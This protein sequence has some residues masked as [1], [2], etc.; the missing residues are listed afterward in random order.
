MGTIIPSHLMR[1]KKQDQNRIDS[2]LISK[3]KLYLERQPHDTQLKKLCD[4]YVRRNLGREQHRHSVHQCCGRKCVS[5]F[6][7]N[8]ISKDRKANIIII[9]CLGAF[10][11]RLFDSFWDKAATERNY[12]NVL[13][14]TRLLFTAHIY[15]RETATK[16]STMKKYILV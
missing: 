10:I 11:T 16:R 3:W 4:C 14:Q 9:F 13:S 15:K 12:Q 8:K 2:D 7:D 6:W 1:C 5:G